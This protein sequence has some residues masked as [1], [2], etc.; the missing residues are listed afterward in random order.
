AG[1]NLPAKRVVVRDVRRY[2]SNYGNVP[3]PV[4]EI[5]QML[6]RAGRP[7]YDTE[8]QAI[9]VAKTE[10]QREELLERYLLGEPE[11][12]YSKLGTEA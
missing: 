6:G 12:I 2:D 4:L 5:K 10:N 1:I 11:H 7:R 8:G 9:L 3:I